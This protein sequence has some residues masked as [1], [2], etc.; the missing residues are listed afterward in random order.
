MV[1]I[2]RNMIETIKSYIA[3]KPEILRSISF[4]SKDHGWGYRMH[5]SS[6]CFFVPE[7]NTITRRKKKKPGKATREIRHRALLHRAF[8]ITIYH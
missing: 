6:F 7:S 4:N 3:K 1:N 5:A 8:T 2:V